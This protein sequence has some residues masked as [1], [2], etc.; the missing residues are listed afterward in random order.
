LTDSQSGL[1]C[2]HALFF[3]LIIFFSFFPDVKQKKIIKKKFKTAVIIVK[4]NK[5]K[6]EL[7][8]KIKIVPAM[9]A[10]NKIIHKT[11]KNV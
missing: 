8:L 4:G 1:I 7:V 3:K 9:P 10:I 6:L 5:E 2:S 11:K